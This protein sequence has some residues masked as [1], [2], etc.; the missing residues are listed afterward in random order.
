MWGAPAPDR[1]PLLSG[2]RRPRQQAFTLKEREGVCF[3]RPCL[4]EVRTGGGGHKEEL[5]VWTAE[6]PGGSLPPALLNLRVSALTLAQPLFLVGF[7]LFLSVC[8][9][10]RLR[11]VLLQQADADLLVRIL[12]PRGL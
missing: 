10:V 12:G 7:F 1:H 9:L 5:R 8:S 6:L 4:L 3:P 11:Q 2:C